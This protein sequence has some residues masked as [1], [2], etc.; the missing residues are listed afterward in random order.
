MRFSC[1]SRSARPTA[2]RCY[3]L[4]L[5]DEAGMRSWRPFY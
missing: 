5:P 2:R 3:E 1:A 4:G